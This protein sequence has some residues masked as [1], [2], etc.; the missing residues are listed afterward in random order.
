VKEKDK[1]SQ[2]TKIDKSRCWGFFDGVLHDTPRVGG[3]GGI[4]HFYEDH[5]L[6]FVVGIG[7]NTNNKAELTTLKILLA[8]DFF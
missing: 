1:I 3:D 4:I 2:G 7:P 8:Q 6:S 5:N